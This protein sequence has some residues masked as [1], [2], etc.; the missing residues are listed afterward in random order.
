MRSRLLLIFALL[1]T[2]HVELHAAGFDKRHVI[3]QGD[4]SP[5]DGLT[6]LYVRGANAVPVMVDDITVIIPSPVDDFI[7][8]NNGNGTFTLLAPLSILQR[9]AARTWPVAEVST[10]LRDIDF[11]GATD[12]VLEDLTDIVSGAFDQTIFAARPSGRQPRML[13]PH[14]L[15]YQS[16]HRDLGRWLMDPDYF[17]N[18]PLKVVSAQ[19]PTPI[20]YASVIDPTDYG[21]LF[22]FI[23]ECQQRNP[24]R[25]CGYTS[26]DP[27]PNSSDPED[28]TRPVILRDPNTLQPIG[29]GVRDVCEYDAHVYVYLPGSVTVQ[30]DTSV[31]NAD[32][33]ESADIL[34]DFRQNCTSVPATGADRLGTILGGVYG[35]SILVDQGAGPSNVTNS[36]AHP[37]FP[38]DEAFDTSDLTFHHYDVST[39]LCRQGTPGCEAT[40][41]ANLLRWFSYPSF[42]LKP[43]RTQVDYTERLWAFITLAPLG[44]SAYVVPAG[45]IKQRL[46]TPPF[47]SG[48]VQNVTQD[49]HLVFPGA[50]TRV[51]R[52]VGPWID[53]FTHGVGINRAF[54][55]LYSPKFPVQMIV[56]WSNDVFGAAAFRSLDKQMKKFFKNSPTALPASSTSPGSSKPEFDFL[57]Q[58]AMYAAP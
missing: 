33:K 19:P 22:A 1:L 49:N 18:V 8:K 9:S 6:D 54:C 20:W 40:H 25:A 44:P 51:I 13:T 11:D 56:G 47:G 34:E 7:L 27:T 46:V 36:F 17:D 31:F 24:N 52:P 14:N 26:I 10:A 35:S 21:A 29:S 45:Q 32:A 37:P 41:L 55:T 30:P 57:D 12:L 42:Q 23:A 4:I 3:Y 2:V 58:D 15:N 28:C 53:V 38:G 50:I 5:A 16:Y 39:E 48:A 43:L